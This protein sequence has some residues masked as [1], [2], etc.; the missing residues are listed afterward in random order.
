M[1][2]ILQHT[3]TWVF[4]LFAVIVWVGYKQTQP[5]NVSLRRASIMPLVMVVFSFT[6]IHSAFGNN[7][8]AYLCWVVGLASVV[9]AASA[10]GWQRK[11]RYLPASHRLELPG[12]WLPLALIL[13]IFFIKYTVAVTLVMHPALRQTM[14]FVAGLCFTYGLFSGLFL[15]RAASPWLL[16]RRSAN[17][18]AAA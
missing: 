14:P 11:A 10:M 17:E 6:G 16:V 9:V 18:L 15:V 1:F 4:A 5:R 12:S 3:P 13:A 8:L 2:A 7:P